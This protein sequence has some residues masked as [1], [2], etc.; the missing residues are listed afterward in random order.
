MEKHAHSPSPHVTEKMAKRDRNLWP[1]EGREPTRAESQEGVCMES[2]GQKWGGERRRKRRKKR[3]RGEGDREGEGGRQGKKE[4]KRGR[5]EAQKC[6]RPK[7][8]LIQEQILDIINHKGKG[9][10]VCGRRTELS[11]PWIRVCGRRTELSIPWILRD[12]GPSGCKLLCS[13]PNPGL[14]ACLAV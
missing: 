9:I 7:C 14:V 11:I 6:R 10:S 2:L 5:N 1:S 8:S 3:E 13:S 4:K 12:F